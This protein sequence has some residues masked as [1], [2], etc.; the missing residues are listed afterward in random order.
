MAA[1]L[2]FVVC[3]ILGYLYYQM[4]VG[5][6]AA[7]QAAEEKE[8]EEQHERDVQWQIERSASALKQMDS[9]L[10]RLNAELERDPGEH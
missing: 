3:F 2:S 4:E 10:E 1:F 9:E 7:K 5:I 8:W 6:P